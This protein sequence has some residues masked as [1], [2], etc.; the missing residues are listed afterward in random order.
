LILIVASAIISAPIRKAA[1]PEYGA[2][3]IRL[4]AQWEFFE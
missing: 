1:V 2:A 3:L 4:L